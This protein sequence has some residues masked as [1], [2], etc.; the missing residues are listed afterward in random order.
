MSALGCKFLESLWP[1]LRIPAFNDDVLPLYV[2]EFPE[3]LEQW[4]IND[5][6]YVCNVR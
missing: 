1:A 3:G 2:P 6:G 5:L 4:L